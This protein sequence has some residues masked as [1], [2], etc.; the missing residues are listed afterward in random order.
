MNYVIGVDQGGSGTRAVICSLDGQLVGKGSGPG[1]CHAFDGMEA[2][3]RATQLAVQAAL[4]HASFPNR[5]VVL[6]EKANT[7]VG[8]HTGADWP[9]EYTLLREGVE[10]LNLA[11]KVVIVNDSIVAGTAF[12][13]LAVLGHFS[14][15]YLFV[16]G[17]GLPEFG[18]RGSLTWFCPL[19]TGGRF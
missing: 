17:L 4:A 19:L 2:A 5:N 7:Y 6:T 11:E 8:G 3:M 12:F 9:D 14:G 13:A 15:I 18:V 16:A 10:T 1:A